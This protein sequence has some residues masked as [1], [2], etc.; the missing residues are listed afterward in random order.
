MMHL[1]KAVVLSYLGTAYVTT[2]EAQLCAIQQRF[3][4]ERS[5]RKCDGEEP[6]VHWVVQETG[7]PLTLQE[8]QQPSREKDSGRVHSLV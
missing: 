4:Q 2:W 6:G 1:G 8:L 5:S 3:A 7:F